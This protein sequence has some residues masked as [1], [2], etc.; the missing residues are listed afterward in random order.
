MEHAVNAAAAK[1]WLRSS[2]ALQAALAAK[3]Q[4]LTHTH[5]HTHTLA[6]KEKEANARV[7]FVPT[8]PWQVHGGLAALI[9][10]DQ[11]ASAIVAEGN[12]DARVAH[13]LVRGLVRRCQKKRSKGAAFWVRGGVGKRRGVRV[14]TQQAKSARGVSEQRRSRGRTAISHEKAP[15]EGPN[16]GFFLRA[17]PRKNRL[18]DLRFPT[19]KNFAILLG[20]RLLV[21]L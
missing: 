15:D 16:H 17:D 8:L 1:D 21:Q 18:D 11:Q 2:S 3:K 13:G 19:S 12:G 9:E 7:P 6:Q 10:G 4:K 20:G 14:I 5:T